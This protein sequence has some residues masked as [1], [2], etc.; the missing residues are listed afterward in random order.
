MRNVG[1]D[2]SLGLRGEAGDF[3]YRISGNLST[4]KNKVVRLGSADIFN[5]TRLNNVN[6]TTEGYPVGM[7]YGYQVVGIYQSAEDVLNYRNENGELILPYAVVSEEDLNPDDW[8]GRY[9][10]ADLNGDG[11]IDA[12]DRGIIGSPH[13]DFT[14]G[15]NVSLTYKN[16]DLSTNFYFSIGNE[17]FRH[18]MY[19]THF[20]ALQGA[21]SR[22]RRDE[23]WHPV[24]NPN[25]I[26]PLWATSQREG[27]EAA[28]ESNSTYL[29][30][31]S[32]LRMQ[33]LTLGYNLPQHILRT[34]RFDRFRIYA[35]I[36]N[37]FTMTK[38]NGLDPELR[39]TSDINKGVDYGSYGMPRQFSIGLNVAFN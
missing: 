31:G 9:K 22:E 19:Y 25:G 27:T 2:L 30:D 5:N 6:I 12:S 1:F 39:S 26:Y 17:I 11:K 33:T 35:Q 24:E 13:P 34:N 20:G 18:F 14:G 16:F 37:V 8:V 3:T 32:Y 4:Y 36:S 7:F 21:Y 28:N 29:S 10:M 23:S 15:A 38:Y